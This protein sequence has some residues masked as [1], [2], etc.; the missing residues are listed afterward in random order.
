MRS[1]GE[2]KSSP[3]SSLRP[4]TREAFISAASVDL[5]NASREQPRPK[6][7]FLID[8][9][10]AAT[11]KS[12]VWLERSILMNVSPTF[13]KSLAVLVVSP[14]S[15][16]NNVWRF[17]SPEKTDLRGDSFFGK[18]C[19]SAFTRFQV[20]PERVSRFFGNVVE[21]CEPLAR[22]FDKNRKPREG[23]SAQD[24]FFL[25]GKEAKEEKALNGSSHPASQARTEKEKKRL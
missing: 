2:K 17:H 16:D 6:I 24:T 5:R 19:A 13:N 4:P 10:R 25:S 20:W 23:L 15:A 22:L 1:V 11:W 18:P 3:G 8:E 7:L 21:C 12:I 9:R 14:A